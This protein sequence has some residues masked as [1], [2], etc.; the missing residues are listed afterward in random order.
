MPDLRIFS[1]LPNPRLYKATIAA[2]FSGADIEIT[3]AKP[4]DLMDWLWD[5]EARKLSEA[6]KE[7]FSDCARQAE[8]GFSGV[9][10]KTD[11]FLKAHPFGSVPAG[12]SGD[13]TVGIFESNAIMRAAARCGPNAPALLGTD[14]MQQ[15]RV[16]AFLDRSLVFARDSQ[17]YLLAGAKTSEALHAEMVTALDTYAG[18][19]DTALHSSACVA[20]DDLS[21]ADIAVACEL[22]LLTNDTRHVDALAS[23]GLEPVSRRL[24]HFPR[25]GAH[26][27]R[28]ASDP[29]F[30]QDL[31]GYFKRLLP[32]WA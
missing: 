18:G 28:L 7:A 17:R 4:L 26:M 23:R 24:I 22:C 16:D 2:R 9:L 13:G 20:G 32:I 12:F 5:F 10:Y 19:L 21:L 6:E 29:R 11:A 14:V 30:S 3:G 15:C 25:L 1:Y 8:T 31:D 27:A